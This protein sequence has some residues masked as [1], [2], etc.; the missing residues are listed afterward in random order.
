M[1]VAEYFRSS[2]GHG[3]GDGFYLVAAAMQIL[4]LVV[5]MA[6]VVRAAV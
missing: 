6:M 2:V 5:M 4:T 1:H 3:L